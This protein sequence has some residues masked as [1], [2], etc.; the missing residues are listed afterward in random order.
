MKKLSFFFSLLLLAGPAFA[1]GERSALVQQLTEEVKL[2]YQTP[3][4]EV[5]WKAPALEVLL[6]GDVPKDVRF[7]IP[8]TAR[9]MGEGTVPIQV[10]RGENLFRTIYPRLNIQVFSFALVSLSRVSRGE[11]LDSGN[12][13]IQRK[14]LQDLPSQPLTKLE[15][16]SNARAKRDIPSGTVL[17]SGLID[18]PSAIKSGSM[19]TVQVLSGD[20]TILSSGQAL[21]DGQIGQL[22][23]IRN[24]ASKREFSGRVLGEGLV[25]VKLE[26]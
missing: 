22:V 6:G 1:G 9:L 21:S 15:G 8:P 10:Y 3:E 25:E 14:R 17:T 7:K 19:V 2:R 5:E 16:L 20:L 18:L 13:Q 12:V 26:D 11:A 24:P 4:V 23:R